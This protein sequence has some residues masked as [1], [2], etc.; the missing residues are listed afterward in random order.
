LLKQNKKKEFAKIKQ[1]DR[2]L[3]DNAEHRKL[4]NVK[5]AMRKNARREKKKR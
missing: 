3:K 4:K 2:K 1:L 5:N